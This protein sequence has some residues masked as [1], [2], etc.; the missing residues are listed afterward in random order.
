MSGT[1]H[2]STRKILIDMFQACQAFGQRTMAERVGDISVGIL[3]RA[4]EPIAQPVIDARIKV[5][6]DLLEDM[7]NSEGASM[8][9]QLQLQVAQSE[10]DAEIIEYEL[11]SITRIRKSDLPKAQKGPD[12]WQNATGIGQLIFWLGPLYD[13]GEDQKPKDV[14]PNA[15]PEDD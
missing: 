4:I 2:K 13:W 1:A 5:A 14:D 15:A 7:D 10:F 3:L 12:G 11:P 9:L 6:G 8:R